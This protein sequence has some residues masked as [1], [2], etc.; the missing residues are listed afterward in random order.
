MI[1]GNYKAQRKIR[2]SGLIVI[3]KKIQN[4]NVLPTVNSLCPKCNGKKAEAWSISI[5][6]EDNSESTFFRCVTCGFTR[7]EN[8]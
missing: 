7:R 1:K 6:S 3:D 4:I 5:G 2:N 8:D